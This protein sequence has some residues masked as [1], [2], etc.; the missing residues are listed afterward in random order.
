MMAT[1]TR[2]MPFRSARGEEILALSVAAQEFTACREILIDGAWAMAIDRIKT[3]AAEIGH[4]IK[5]ERLESSRK[6]NKKKADK[7]NANHAL[8]KQAGEPLRAKHPEKSDL[9]LAEQIAKKVL[10]DKIATETAGSKKAGSEKAASKHTI[11]AV[12]PNL[13]LSK[14]DPPIKN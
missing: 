8:W 1:P 13:G 14:K 6:G 11:R 7:A 4:K 2:E 9:W 12:L 10:A 5:Q 3:R